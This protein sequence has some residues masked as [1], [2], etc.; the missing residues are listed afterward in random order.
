MSSIHQMRVEFIP[1]EDRLLLSVISRDGM[2]VKLWLTR[3]FVR[4]LWPNL[5]KLAES[6]PEA[7]AQQSP[8]AKSSIMRFQHEKALAEARFGKKYDGDKVVDRP[9]GE[10]PL[11]VTKGQIRRV[12]E[13]KVGNRLAFVSQDDKPITLTLDDVLLHSLCRLIREAARKAEWDLGLG[14]LSAESGAPG[15]ARPGAAI[16]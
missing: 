4:L 3:R 6:T 16:N 15:S 8:E 9:F 13:P 5:L 10:A 2:E 1:P 14:G 11:L 7:A 12:S